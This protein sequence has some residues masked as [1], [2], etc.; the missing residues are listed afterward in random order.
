MKRILKLFLI[1]II[2]SIALIPVIARES[3][4]LKAGVSIE[5]VPKAIFGSW[6][7]RAEI[8]DSSNYKVFKPKSTDLWN[9]SRRGDVL[10]LS[11]P[12]TGASADVS[13]NAAQ[14]NVVSFTRKVD[15]DNHQVLIDV[16]TV[17][18][19][20]NTFSGINEIRLEQYSPV[21]NKI[22]KSDKAR[23]EIKGDKIS[24]ESVLK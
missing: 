7:V 9:I 5:E 19:N 21:N 24:G 15:F 11:N 12:F 20:E 2:I 17:R 6:S 10:N 1:I 14:G 3:Y 4:V 22:I 8:V 23:Y 18:L 16:V 13:I